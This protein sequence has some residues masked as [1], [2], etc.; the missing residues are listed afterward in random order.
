MPP[1]RNH[2]D[3]GLEAREVSKYFGD[4]PALKRVTLRIAAGECALIYGANGAGKTTLLRVLASLTEPSAGEIWLG[5]R[6]VD[7][8]T[9]ALKSRVG[10]VSHATFLYGDL[11]VEENLVLAAKL[12]GLSSVRSRVSAVIETFGLVDRARQSVRSLSRGLQQRATLARAMLHE[13]DFLLL[14]E[15]FTG[16]DS[17][18]VAS[19][20]ALLRRLPSQ[21]K[22]VAFSTHNFAQGISIAHRLVA[23]ERG[24]VS[25]DGPVASAPAEYSLRAP[26]A[27]VA[28]S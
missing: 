21:G 28:R 12:F 2:N 10:F 6:K 7:R 11:T 19:L 24:R 13:P 4:F 20:E 5:G 15:P 25:Y 22:A 17:T 27:E 9:V 8:R 3:S 23:V 18:A 16:L 14:D 26:E 1:D